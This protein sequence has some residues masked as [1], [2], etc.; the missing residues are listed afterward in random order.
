VSVI[1]DGENAWE[2]YPEN[3][4]HFLSGLYKAVSEHPALRLTTFSEHLARR[5]DVARLDTLVPGSWV[6]GT[7]S[8]WIGEP[9]KNRAWDLLVRAKSDFDAKVA[10]GELHGAALERAEQ[11]LKVCEGSDW[12]W[13]FGDY[14]PAETVSDFDRLFR[15][16]VRDLYALMDLTVPAAV[17]AV[18]G[19]G[20][21]APVHGGA[22]RENPEPAG[23]ATA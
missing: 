18:I 12:F 13:W 16:H 10:S 5:R 20:A 19:V 15:D 22:M 11:Q 21:G 4:Y 2:H 17:D 6:Y 3:G 9:D 23:G 1:L 7:F 8:T 14:N